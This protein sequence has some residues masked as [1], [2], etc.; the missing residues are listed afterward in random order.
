LR[1][2]YDEWYLAIVT[3]REGRREAESLRSKLLAVI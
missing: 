1:S 2:Y 3:S